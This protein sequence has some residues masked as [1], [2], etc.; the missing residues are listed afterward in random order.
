MAYSL[1]FRKRSILCCVELHY[2]F[3]LRMLLRRELGPM[4]SRKT[5]PKCNSTQH[6]PA[7][8][9]CNPEMVIFKKAT[10]ASNLFD[11]QVA[12]EISVQNAAQ[13]SIWSSRRI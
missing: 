8:L 13:W 6:Y 11:L 2:R 7:G 12:A 1:L 5:V 4:S 10:F 3:V 9:Q